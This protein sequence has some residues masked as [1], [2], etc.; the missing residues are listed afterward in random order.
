M[1]FEQGLNHS[2]NY[3]LTELLH[4]I[5]VWKTNYSAAGVLKFNSAMILKYSAAELLIKEQCYR[6]IYQST[7]LQEY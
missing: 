3:P 4:M 2:F 1:Q 7:V 6:G 5:G